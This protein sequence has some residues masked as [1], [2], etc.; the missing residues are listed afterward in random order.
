[1]SRVEQ[2]LRQSRTT[3]DQIPYCKSDARKKEG[4]IS[5]NHALVLSVVRAQF[6]SAVDCRSFL[7]KPFSVLRDEAAWNAPLNKRNGHVREIPSARKH[8]DVP[9]QIVNNGEFRIEPSEAIEH[10]SAACDHR[11]SVDEGFGQKPYEEILITQQSVRVGLKRFSSRI[12]FDVIGIAQVRLRM[13]VK[14]GDLRFEIRRTP[15]IIVVKKSDQVASR[16]LDSKVAR[17]RGAGRSLRG[18]HPNICADAL[19][20]L[21]RSV[22]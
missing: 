18:Q 19:K 10:V 16:L 20:P 2:C 9:V 3:E 22:T 1:M 15:R 8:V 14:F 4:P 13:T 6:E 12:D 7:R 11:Q 5:A 17:G 21:S